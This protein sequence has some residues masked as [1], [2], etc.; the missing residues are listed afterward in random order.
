MMVKLIGVAMIRWDLGIVGYVASS[1]QDIE[2]TYSNVFLRCYPTT[3]DMTK[4][5]SGKVSCI[6]NTMLGSLPIRALAIILDPYGIANDVGTRRRV[7][8]SVVLDGVYSWFAN[9]LRSRSLV[10][11]EDDLEV[12]GELLSLTRFI[13]ARVDGYASALAG[14]VSTIIRAKGVD[15]SKLPID[16]VDVREEARKYVEES[17]VRV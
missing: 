9:Y 11:E 12:N 5:S 17:V 14:V 15:V 1:P 6:V 2:A 13:R 10:N 16:I 7:R 8:R 3:L 4:E